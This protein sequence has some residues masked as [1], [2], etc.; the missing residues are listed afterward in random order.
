MCERCGEI[1][2][3]TGRY[4]WLAR[5]ILDRGALEALEKLV[6]KLAAEKMALHPTPKE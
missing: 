4:R 2:N 5:G 1:D 6:A 3:S